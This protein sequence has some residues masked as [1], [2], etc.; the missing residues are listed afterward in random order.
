MK[1]LII[2]LLFSTN[3]FSQNYHYA[4]GEI[5][6]GATPEPIYERNEANLLFTELFENS[7]L[8]LDPYLSDYNPEFAL[9]H[10]FMLDNNIKR[11]GTAGGRFEIRDS[12]P[13]IWG[14]NRAEYAQPS[15]SSLN[16]GWFGFSSY[17]PSS[18]VSDPT[19]EVIGQWHDIP[20]QGETNTRNPSNAIYAQN[21]KFRWRTK[22]DADAIQTNNTTDGTWDADLG[23]IP[24]DQWI[25]W[26][27]HIK[28]SH[29]DTGILEV[30]MNGVKVI[31]RQNMPN[32]YNDGKFPYLKFGI[33]RWQWGTPV[34]QRV[35]YYDEVRVGNQNSSY[36]EVKPGN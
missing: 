25:D 31:D 34:N 19:A 23:V 6:S 14:G 13:L 3:L 12:D 10:S 28:F 16:E 26:V 2:L 18:F 11:Y 33:Y 5:Q 21:D 35:I 20:D 22:W 27:V 7:N 30:W 24:K 29:T 8:D 4:L 15:S 32:S 9:A 17:F 36:E 1:Y